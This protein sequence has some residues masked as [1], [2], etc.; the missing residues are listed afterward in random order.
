LER[1]L[2]ALL[3]DPELL[4]R[5][6]VRDLVLSYAV[7]L[8]QE[9]ASRSECPVVRETAKITIADALAAVEAAKSECFGKVKRAGCASPSHGVS[10][11]QEVG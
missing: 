6:P 9:R 3:A 7:T 10:S 2:D 1:K 4:Q 11:I 8:D 5:T